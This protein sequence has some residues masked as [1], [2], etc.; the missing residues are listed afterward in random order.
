MHAESFIQIVKLRI[1]ISLSFILTHFV[2]FSM[3]LPA[4]KQS[5][6]SLCALR[7]YPLSLPWEKAVKYYRLIA[8]MRSLMCEEPLIQIIIEVST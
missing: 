6:I 5:V 1:D 8:M 3:L 4:K 2:P 7:M